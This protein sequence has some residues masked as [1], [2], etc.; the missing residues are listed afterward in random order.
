MKRIEHSL[1]SAVLLV[2][3]EN[4]WHLLPHGIHTVDLAKI[5]GY[6]M[7]SIMHFEFAL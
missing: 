4:V 7:S 5:L 2:P 1:N 3:I 6:L